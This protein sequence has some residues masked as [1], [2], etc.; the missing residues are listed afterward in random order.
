[1]CCAL[2]PTVELVDEPKPNSGAKLR[3]GDPKRMLSFAARA[4]K[5]RQ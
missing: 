5:C 3:V 2:V 1:M 4:Q